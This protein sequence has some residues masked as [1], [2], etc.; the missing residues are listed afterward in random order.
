MLVNQ[1]KRLPKPSTD[2]GEAEA[3]ISEDA[4]PELERRFHYSKKAS[5]KNLKALASSSAEL[6]QTLV[7]V[8]TISGKEISADFK[9]YI[10]SSF[11][12]HFNLNKKLVKV[13]HWLRK[14]LHRLCSCNARLQLGA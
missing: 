10:F 12:L 14:I 1:N 13:F 6:L 3:Y 7:D 11:S 2:M 8:F 5:T 4:K 9:V